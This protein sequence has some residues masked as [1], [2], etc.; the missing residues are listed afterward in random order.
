MCIACKERIFKGGVDLALIPF[1]GKSPRYI[2]GQDNV[3][4]GVAALHLH[5]VMVGSLQHVCTPQCCGCIAVL[6]PTRILHNSSSQALQG[7]IIGVHVEDFY[8]VVMWCNCNRDELPVQH[9]VGAEQKAHMSVLHSNFWKQL[10]FCAA[11]T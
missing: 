4:D 5:A 3:R 10:F 8:T 1:G 7:H 11:L 2:T 6:N 9:L